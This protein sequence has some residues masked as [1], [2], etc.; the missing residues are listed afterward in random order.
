MG[1]EGRRERGWE[2]VWFA[3]LVC[4]RKCSYEMATLRRNESEGLIPGSFLNP[5][6]GEQGA[7]QEALVGAGP[8][9]LPQ[10]A[11]G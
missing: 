2:K 8:K 10:T 6:F 1:R 9:S 3:I 11:C 7:E 5:S 4:G